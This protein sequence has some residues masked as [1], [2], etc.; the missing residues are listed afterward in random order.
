MDN[1]ILNADESDS[2]LNNGLNNISNL[3]ESYGKSINEQKEIVN[4]HLLLFDA[5][6]ESLERDRKK[7][8]Q[9][10]EDVFYLDLYFNIA[11]Y[12]GSF[13]FLLFL[14]YGIFHR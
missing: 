3:L 2:N 13:I 14:L 7:I 1:I 10:E 9:L 11:L 8:K 5:V 6:L 4:Q 12:L